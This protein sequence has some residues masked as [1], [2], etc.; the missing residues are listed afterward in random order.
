MNPLE[1][2]EVSEYANSNIV[3]FH[4]RRIASLEKLTLN[5]V[6]KKNPHNRGA[7]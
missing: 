2:A 1:L 5:R 7:I 4:Q 3:H 6:L